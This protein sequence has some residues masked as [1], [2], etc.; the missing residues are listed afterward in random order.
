MARGKQKSKVKPPVAPKG[1][2]AP[3]APKGKKR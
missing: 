3:V 1:P 2:K